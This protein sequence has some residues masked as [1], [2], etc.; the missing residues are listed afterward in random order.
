MPD[1]ILG[2]T[3][4]I[5][6]T[7]AIVSGVVGADLPAVVILILGFVNLIADGISM[8]ASNILSRRS[9]AGPG[10]LPT[11]RTASRHGLATF[12]G[13]VL[14]GLVPL[15]AYLLPIAADRFLAAAILALITLFLIGA[16]RAYFTPRHWLAAGVE[17]LGLG[18]I[19]GAAAYGVG[20]LGAWL[21]GSI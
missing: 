4:G 16:G 1:F 20:A 5:I 2:A 3:D 18:T 15:L 7:L 17:M 9:S 12:L 13:F 8:G 21:V 14:A 11:F 19:A 6:T 10:A